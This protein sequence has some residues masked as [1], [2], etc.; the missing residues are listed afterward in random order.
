[1]EESKIRFLNGNALKI[2]GLICMVID[3]VGYMFF[4]D[5]ALLRIIGRLSFPIFAFMIAEGC[6]YT[7]NKLRYF[8]S[9]FLLAL[10]CQIAVFIFDGSTKIYS[11]MSLAISIPIIYLLQVFKKNLFVKNKTKYIYGC[12][13]IFSVLSVC[14]LN[15]FIEIDYGFW[16]TMLAV[17][18]SL[19]KNEKGKEDNLYLSLAF[20]GIGLI[21]LA[22]STFVEQYYALLSLPLL[23]LYSGKR[24][25]LNMKW[26]FY[27]F[28]PAHFVILELIYLIICR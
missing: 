20:L 17:F 18:A 19:F 12:L 8:L 10:T 3:H 11:L 23:C 4:E 16:G 28:Y 1:M 15:K 9:V 24:G 6:K 14:V 22:M 2:I 21:F 7:K 25:N 5:C 13:L 27:L 26:F